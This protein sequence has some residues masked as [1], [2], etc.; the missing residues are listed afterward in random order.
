MGRL[1]EPELLEDGPTSA[2]LG[3]IRCPEDT[4]NCLTVSSAKSIALKKTAADSTFVYNIRNRSFASGLRR[5]NIFMQ[6][7]LSGQTHRLQD[8]DDAEDASEAE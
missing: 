7:R 8:V 4:D 6:A 5:L 1:V 2:S 3:Y